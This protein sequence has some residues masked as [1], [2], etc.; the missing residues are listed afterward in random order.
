MLVYR[1]FGLAAPRTV[2][3]NFFRMTTATAESREYGSWLS[4]TIHLLHLV[5]LTARGSPNLYA[6]TSRGQ[7]LELSSIEKFASSAAKGCGASTP[8]L[9]PSDRFGP[10]M[11]CHTTIFL[12]GVDK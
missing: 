11:L 1:V 3:S 9:H 12:P 6:W 10:L 7:L 8:A 5:L 4:T 2:G